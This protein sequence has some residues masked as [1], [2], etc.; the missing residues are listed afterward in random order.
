MVGVFAFFNLICMC[1][2]STVTGLQSYSPFKGSVMEIMTIWRKKPCFDCSFG[3]G[4]EFE[5]VARH[6][7]VIQQLSK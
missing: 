3:G 6:F 4:F 2:H 7:P 5:I 1:I